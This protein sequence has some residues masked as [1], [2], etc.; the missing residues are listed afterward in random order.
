[1]AQFG[2]PS[3]LIPAH[4]CRLPLFCLVVG[5]INLICKDR[6]P[7]VR[8]HNTLHMNVWTTLRICDPHG[9]QDAAQR[10]DSVGQLHGAP[11]L[12]CN[13]TFRLTPLPHGTGP[14]LTV[15]QAATGT[16]GDHAS[17]DHTRLV[18]ALRD[19][20][21]AG[22]SKEP[23]ADS[24]QLEDAVTSDRT[25]ET[26]VCNRQDRALCQRLVAIR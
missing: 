25:K 23:I 4:L 18:C 3:Q 1:M 26:G 13:C 11:G 16:A 20:G 17:C 2:F 24:C 14:F 6:H 9:G 21:V 8:N 12:V 22:L 7:C 15:I 19:L 10:Q 5:R